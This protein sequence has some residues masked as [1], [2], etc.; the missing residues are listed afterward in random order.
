MTALA[1]ER[2]SSIERW[3]FKQ[4]TLA[5]GTKAWKNGMACI[6]LSTGKV[7][8]GVLDATLLYIGKFA[9]TVDAT[10]GDK[11]VNVELGKEI[12]VIWWANDSVAPVDAGDIGNLCYI[13]DDQTVSMTSTGASIAGRV[14]A[15]DSIKGVAVEK[16]STPA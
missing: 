7:V 4:F 10:A 11:L 5:S 1:K 16:L 2:M 3:G 13:A 15:V 14:W 8:P 12:E 6:E 9:E